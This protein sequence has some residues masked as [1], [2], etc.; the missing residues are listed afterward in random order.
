M[1]RWIT[2]PPSAGTFS[3]QA[4]CA[5]PENTY[6]RE[7]GREGFFGPTTHLHH[8]HAPTGWVKWEGPL[9]PRAFDFVKLDA[10]TDCPWKAM[11]TMGNRSFALRFWR[12]N[13]KMQHLVAN[14]DG[15]ELL[16]VHA[17]SGDLYCDFGRLPF[18]EGDYI[19]LPR[20]TMWRIECAEPCVFLLIEATN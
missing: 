19:L 14:G 5:L 15:D 9:K 1:K 6:E 7:F 12:T 20:A 3:R 4:H 11:E 17:G 18:R 10:S 13:A 2:F 16:F 8:K